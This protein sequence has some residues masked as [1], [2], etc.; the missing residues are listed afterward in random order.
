M[1]TPPLPA[2]I[3][4]EQTGPARGSP[5]GPGPILSPR[6][7]CGVLNSG[8]PSFLL[9]SIAGG[10]VELTSY[11]GIPSPAPWRPYLLFP[12]TPLAP[13]DADMEKQGSAC[14]I[15]G[16]GNTSQHGW[17]LASCSG[18]ECALGASQP[19]HG[20]GR[21]V[22][23]LGATHSF[24]SQPAQGGCTPDPRGEHPKP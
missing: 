7:R 6:H 4:W 12:T 16:D 23:A 3:G 1:N 8:D 9:L 15:S 13:V 19:Q 2:C 20:I 22:G 18:T 14:T 10:A 11:R 5:V 21:K 24:P 17:T